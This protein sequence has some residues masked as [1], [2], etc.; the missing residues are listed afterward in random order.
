MSHQPATESTPLLDA[1][2][3][4]PGVSNGPGNRALAFRIATAASLV[5]GVLTLIFLATCMILLSGAPPTY[6]PPYQIYYTFASVAGFVSSA[7]PCP[8][9]KRALLR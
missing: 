4:T 2:A 5:T 3:P 1:E 8:R 7:A 9:C 6:Y